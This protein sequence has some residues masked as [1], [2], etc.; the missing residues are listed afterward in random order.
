VNRTLYPI[1]LTASAAVATLF[2]ATGT[3]FAATPAPVQ[4]SPTALPI[5]LADDAIHDWHW[6]LH[7]RHA[8]S[9]EI[10]KDYFGGSSSAGGPQP[11]G[12]LCPPAPPPGVGQWRCA[13]TTVPPVPAP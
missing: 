6:H 13:Y 1:A 8:D 5:Q 3:A 7:H 2:V 9:Q 11:I 4:V 12:L 10:M